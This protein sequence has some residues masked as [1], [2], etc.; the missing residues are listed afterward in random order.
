[1]EPLVNKWLDDM[2]EDG[3]PGWEVYERAKSMPNNINKIMAKALVI[4]T[5]SPL[6]FLSRDLKPRERKQY[7]NQTYGSE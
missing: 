6:C 7:S 4:S 1:V 2:E 5:L 3:L